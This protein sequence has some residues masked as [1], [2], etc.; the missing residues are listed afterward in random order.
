VNICVS[1]GRRRPAG[2]GWQPARGR[3]PRYHLACRAPRPRGGPL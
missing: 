2:P 1:R 3:A